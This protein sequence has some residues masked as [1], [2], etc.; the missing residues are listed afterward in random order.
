MILAIFSLGD[1]EVSWYSSSPISPLLQAFVAMTF[2]SCWSTSTS[3]SVS[4][5]NASAW[6]IISKY[7][8]PL[9]ILPHPC[10]LHQLINDPTQNRPMQYW[11]SD[12]HHGCMPGRRFLLWWRRS[13]PSDR[14]MAVGYCLPLSGAQKVWS[15]T[16][17]THAKVCFIYGFIYKLLRAYT[18]LWLYIIT[19]NCYLGCTLI[20]SCTRSTRPVLWKPC[21]S[22][23]TWGVR[24]S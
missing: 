13:P 21:N 20:V 1:S 9:R 8:K 24:H 17:T 4:S 7:G 15:H 3:V 6:G 11:L 5:L 2:D 18:A 12:D 19:S 10:T 16:K 23:Q 22:D 14:S